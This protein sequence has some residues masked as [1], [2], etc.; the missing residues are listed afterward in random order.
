[1][2][3]QPGHVVTVLSPDNSHIVPL[4]E[5]ERP[6]M[7]IITDYFKELQRNWAGQR[8]E[9]WKQQN[10]R[11]VVVTKAHELQPP[12]IILINCTRFPMTRSKIVHYIG[13]TVNSLF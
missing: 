12:V 2:G 4:T 5:R 7:M 1:M 10:N 9:D 6:W 8:R 11:Y 13:N 3:L